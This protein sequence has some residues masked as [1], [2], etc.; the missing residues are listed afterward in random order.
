[1]S[2]PA[3]FAS[4]TFGIPGP[5]EAFWSTIY[6]AGQKGS[7]YFRLA[8]GHRKKMHRCVQ[9]SGEVANPATTEHIAGRNSSRLYFPAFWRSC[10]N[11]L[12]WKR[13]RLVGVGVFKKLFT[14]APAAPFFL[15][16]LLGGL[17][18]MQKLGPLGQ[19]RCSTCLQ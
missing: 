16:H 1:M 7:V 9:Q 3:E 12:T 19:N 11:Y 5:M 2:T 17:A 15:V 4:I 8:F 13:R 6:V 14:V 10:S 18:T